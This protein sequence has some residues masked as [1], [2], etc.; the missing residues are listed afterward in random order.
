MREAS[1]QQRASQYTSLN[2]S[3]QKLC[4]QHK[5]LDSP[6]AR[7]T[8]NRHC[9]QH[10][11]NCL[12]QAVAR[13][14]DAGGRVDVALGQ[15]GARLLKQQRVRQ[16]VASRGGQLCGY[17]A[18]ARPVAAARP[19]QAGRYQPRRREHIPARRGRPGARSRAPTGRAACAGA[20][21]AHRSAAACRA[22]SSA[23]SASAGAAPRPAP[24]SNAPPSGAG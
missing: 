2:P 4:L 17:P 6:C 11:Q 10:P 7:C 3:V 24:L 18:V 22:A 16:A 14:Q 1:I 21:R 12:C 20:R 9:R 15:R 5:T 13:L 8:C 19:A 23:D